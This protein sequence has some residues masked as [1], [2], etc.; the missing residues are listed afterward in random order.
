MFLAP[1][2][3]Q[4]EDL[5]SDSCH[6]QPALNLW[7]C[8]WVHEYTHTELHPS[9]TN[10]PTTHPWLL[11]C[12][13]SLYNSALPFTSELIYTSS[14]L[15]WAVSTLINSC[16]SIHFPKPK[17]WTLVPTSPA[18]RHLFRYCFEVKMILNSPTQYCNG[19]LSQRPRLPC[20][21]PTALHHTQACA[22]AHTHAGT[23]AKI[24]FCDIS[25]SWADF[26]FSMAT[27]IYSWLPPSCPSSSSSPSHPHFHPSSLEL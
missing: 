25:P 12:L 18:P 4:Q 13:S 6:P 20:L 27:W 3:H 24:W 16:H 21:S 10:L 8:T 15:S 23:Q 26:P 2:P 14:L 9:P 22:K 11:T 7:A 19:S 1:R 5:E 17:Y